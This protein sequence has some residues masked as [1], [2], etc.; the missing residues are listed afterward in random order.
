ML[1]ARMAAWLVWQLSGRKGDT[2]D[3]PP[4]L[5]YHRVLPEFL[6]DDNAPIYSI[7]PETFESQM[8]FLNRQGF[9]SL[10]IREYAEIARGLRPAPPRSVLITF[11]DGYGDNYAIAWEIA[12]RHKIKLNLFIC[13][14]IIDLMTPVVM[15][16]DGCV[17]W[18]ESIQKELRP[19]LLSHIRRYPH[20]W[21]PM[22]WQE[23]GEMRD[24]GVEIG[25]HS[26][27]H[28]NL[29]RLTP[30]ELAE[31]IDTGVAIF[32][33]RLGNRPA[34]F[35]L[36]YGCYGSYSSEVTA[37]LRRFEPEVIFSTHMGRARLPSDR[38]IFPRH[39]VHQAD[40]L[41]AFHRKLLG[42]YDWVE[43]VHWIKYCISTLLRNR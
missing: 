26:H 42:A 14:A 7:R 33:K 5:C 30:V 12:Q 11:D 8:A 18:N 40:N 38:L 15:M 17:P 24:A 34:F 29:A 6:E 32:Q 3:R 37:F 16:E 36:P 31:D 27:G 13:T 1:F 23:L 35:A 19:D 21:R 39:C 41:D 10:S 2:G 22:T 28:R 4:V 9:R 20:L 25:F 43:R